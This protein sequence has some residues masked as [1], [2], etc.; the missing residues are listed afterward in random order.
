[1]NIERMSDGRRKVTSITELTGMKE[2]EIEL[3]EIFAFQ[4]TG[5]TNNKEVDGEYIFN[6]LEIPNVYQKISS[7]GI[8]DLDDMFHQE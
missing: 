1:M 4:Q 5:L 2:N 3:R 6:H 8:T 7:K